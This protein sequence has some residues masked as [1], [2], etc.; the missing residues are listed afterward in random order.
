M[1]ALFIT[2]LNNN[3]N[4]G[5]CL[6]HYQMAVLLLII[7][8]SIFNVNLVYYLILFQLRKFIFCLNLIK[9]NFFFNFFYC[10]IADYLT[11]L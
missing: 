11:V 2:I 7:N 5:Y 4:I 1:Q 8:L 3:F 6:V 9:I 10:M